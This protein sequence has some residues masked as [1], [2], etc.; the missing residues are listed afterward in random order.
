MS[1]LERLAY[2]V[3]VILMSPFCLYFLYVAIWC[4]RELRRMDKQGREST[5][6]GA[7]D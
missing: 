7:P 3:F 5:H 4:T 2:L 1:D 6:P